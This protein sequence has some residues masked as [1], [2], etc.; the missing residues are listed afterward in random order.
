MT[1]DKCKWTYNEWDGYY[2]TGCKQAFTVEEGCPEDNHMKYCCYCGKELEQVMTQN[3][4]LE[5]R[6]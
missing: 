3:D 4:V 2:D 1:T 6:W 5:A